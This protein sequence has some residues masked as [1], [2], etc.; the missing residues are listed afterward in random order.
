MRRRE[1]EERCARN[2]GM[3]LS[4]AIEIFILYFCFVF[5]VLLPCDSSFSDAVSGGSFK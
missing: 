4:R 5:P 2:W 1:R 3:R